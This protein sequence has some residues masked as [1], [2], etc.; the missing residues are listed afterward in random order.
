[1][2]GARADTDM[3]IYV[4]VLRIS[5]LY[6]VAERVQVFCGAIEIGADMTMQDLTS[7]T[8]GTDQVHACWD[9]YDLA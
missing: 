1:M 2:H 5:M 7:P 8:S 3:L 4:C 9:R 6:L